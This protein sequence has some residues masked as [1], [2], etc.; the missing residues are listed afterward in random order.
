MLGAGFTY[1]GPGDRAALDYPGGDDP[2]VTIAPA[3]TSL[4]FYAIDFHIGQDQGANGGGVLGT[5]LS[6]ARLRFE[7]VGFISDPNGS[8][9]EASVSGNGGGLSL[10]VDNGSRVTIA[11][12]QFTELEANNGG[13]FDITVRGGSHVT[14]R[15]IQVTGNDATGGQGGGGRII[16]HSGYVTITDSLFSGNSADDGGALRIER[17]SGATGPAEVWI[18]NTRFV[19]N[20]ASFNDDISASGFGSNLHVLDEPVALPLVIDGETP[21][22]QIERI[23][24]TGNNYSVEFRAVGF[25][26]AINGRHV[27]FFFDPVPPEQAG[28]PG[29]GPWYMYAGASPFNLW[30][31]ADR[32]PGA[33]R[34]CIL[35]ANADHSVI[36]GT[37]NCLRL[38]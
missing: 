2:I 26:P 3:V 29:T 36:Q 38:P 20:D 31:V 9:S 34:M 32:P 30:G 37:G 1:G 33:T 14:L 10:D 23:T 22:A 18:V 5:G 28:T 21:G 4:L 8:A 12:S 7:Q 6:N 27:H 13:G 19:N 24:R 17:A 35:V 15:N 16:I 25:T 11:D